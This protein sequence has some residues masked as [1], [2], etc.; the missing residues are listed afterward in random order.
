M[1][2]G[3]ERRRGSEEDQGARGWTLS[4]SVNEGGDLNWKRSRWGSCT[5]S[6]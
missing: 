2:G 5:S 6:S 1:R 4:G 3:L